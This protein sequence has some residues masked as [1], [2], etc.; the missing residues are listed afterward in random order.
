MFPW[1]SWNE[2]IWKWSRCDKRAPHPKDVG[3]K[4]RAASSLSL[5]LPTYLQMLGKHLCSQT[6][7]YFQFLTQGLSETAG[8]RR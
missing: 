6:F 2:F 1:K 5:S 3:G 7:Y 4:L 8:F